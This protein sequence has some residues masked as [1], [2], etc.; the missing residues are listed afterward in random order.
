MTP[1]LAV[2][3]AGQVPTFRLKRP[4]DIPALRAWL[5]R[6]PIFNEVEVVSDRENRSVEFLLCERT[7]ASSGSPFGTLAKRVIVT[8]REYEELIDRASKEIMRTI[9]DG[10]AFTRA[11]SAVEEGGQS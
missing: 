11:A 4:V 5:A 3:D 7:R 10:T 2:Q 1:K 8:P 9:A 6:G